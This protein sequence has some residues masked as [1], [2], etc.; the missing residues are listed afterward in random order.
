MVKVGLCSKIINKHVREEH[1][2]HLKH[3]FSLF[4]CLKP[5]SMIKQL[6]WL[7]LDM[8]KP[9][10]FLNVC[11]FPTLTRK[12]YFDSSEVF[13]VFLCYFSFLPFK[14]FLFK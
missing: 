6:L 9:K 10:Y 4:E 11:L 13:P 1:F 8:L 12:Q 2:E 5:N 7:R 14:M 3:I